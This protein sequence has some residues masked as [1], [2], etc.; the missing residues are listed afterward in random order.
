MTSE[1]LRLLSALRSVL[2]PK[3]RDE[4][5]FM[6]AFELV[7]R[8]GAQVLL[9]R[10]SRILHRVHDGP[11]VWV[12]DNDRLTMKA[13]SV[14]KPSAK[15]T[16][17]VMFHPLSVERDDPRKAYTRIRS[18]ARH[19]MSVSY[20]VS[21]VLAFCGDHDTL[22]P[23]YEHVFFAPYRRS[24][25][26]DDR[27]AEHNAVVIAGMMLNRMDCPY[28]AVTD[29]FRLAPSRGLGGW[30]ALLVVNPMVQTRGR[31]SGEPSDAPGT[32]VHLS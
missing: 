26:S 29:P 18:I 13:L 14:E 1:Q 31:D 4:T 22:E 5:E 32:D 28:H 21:M 24:L 16:T 25:Y 15:V 30:A 17:T 19:R 12:V 11:H 8:H 10:V 6:D 9:H 20:H 2:D 27:I 23:Y 7:G 3:R